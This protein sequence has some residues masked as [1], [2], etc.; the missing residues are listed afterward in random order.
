MSEIEI[1]A[2]YQD[3][4]DWLSPIGIPDL[5]QW[6]RVYGTDTA[7]IATNNGDGSYSC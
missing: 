1:L 4:D 6:Q 7:G 2:L 3:H 5:Y